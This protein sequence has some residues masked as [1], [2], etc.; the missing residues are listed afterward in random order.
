MKK[1]SVISKIYDR[2]TKRSKTEK[3]F[4][5]KQTDIPAESPS[6]IEPT[7]NPTTTVEK[8]IE[9]ADEPPYKMKNY[10][11]VNLNQDSISELAEDN[12]FFKLKKKELFDENLEGETIYQYCFPGNPIELIIE[13][14]I[15]S[16]TS[17][18][19]NL[20]N[21]P[22]GYIKKG[23]VKHVLNIL[24]NN[25]I[26]NMYCDITGGK[27]KELYI[28]DEDLLELD[29]EPKASDYDLLTGSADWGIVLTIVEWQ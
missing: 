7:E 23:S 18:L 11:L 15:P 25:R 5:E 6:V 17:I 22:I 20:K 14:E 3:F 4:D 13:S 29:D 12:P 27:Y 28:D 1:K 19:V 2:I 10:H 26:K 21:T 9:K 16:D 8:P 24:K